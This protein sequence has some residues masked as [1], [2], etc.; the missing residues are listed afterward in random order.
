MMPAATAMAMSRSVAMM[1]ET[2]FRAV[3]CIPQG[4]HWGT[5]NG[6]EQLVRLRARRFPDG[7]REV[8]VR[9]FWR[10][11][12]CLLRLSRPVKVDDSRNFHLE[13]RPSPLTLGKWQPR[14]MEG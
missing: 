8:P 11:R 1:G 3:N 13:R 9:S 5:Y 6:L 10:L 7:H 12:G 2:A 4:D 14:W